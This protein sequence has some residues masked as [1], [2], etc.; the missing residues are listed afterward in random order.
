MLHY[1]L[2]MDKTTVNR[3]L[4]LLM[5]CALL[6]QVAGSIVGWHIDFP[7]SGQENHQ[8]LHSAAIEQHMASHHADEDSNNHSDEHHHHC[9]NC[10]TGSAAL[11]LYPL[12]LFLAKTQTDIPSFESLN[13]SGILTDLLI[14]P[15]IA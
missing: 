9:G 4:S 12:P 10:T 13:Y 15:P 5:A 6:V 2:I 3:F 7:P 14:R 8:T 1:S 11:P